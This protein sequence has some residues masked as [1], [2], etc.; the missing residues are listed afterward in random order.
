MTDNIILSI[1][2][3]L[4]FIVFK[5]CNMPENSMKIKK[6]STPDL[7]CEKI[8]SLIS[9]GTWEQ[10]KKIP[11]ESELA[12]TF[13]VNRFT[14]RMALQKLNTLGILDT[15]VGDGTYVSS[16]NFE[17]HIQEIAEFYMTPELLDD[18]SEFRM[19]IEVECAKLAIQRATNEELSQLENCCKEFE[20]EVKEYVSTST[21]SPKRKILMEKLTDKDIELHNQICKMAHNELLLFSFSTAKEVIR[22][23]MLTI[24]HKRLINLSKNDDIP[25]IKNHWDIYYSIKNRD[26]EKCKAILTSMIDYHDTN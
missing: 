15:R 20:V 14:V 25:T 22:E 26:F 19:L 1:I 23:Y 12:D 16:F 17:K 3:E 10:N 4:I 9:E 5:E 8:K 21:N 11:S 13:G 18:V 2:I 6:T 24:G 7:I